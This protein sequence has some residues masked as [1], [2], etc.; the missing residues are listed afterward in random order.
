MK[1]ILTLALGLALS[2]ALASAQQSAVNVKVDWGRVVTTSR[3]TASYQVVVN[4]MLERG[5]KMHDGTFKA[6]STAGADYV[7]YVPW[8]PY[9]RLGVAELEPPTAD[10]TS[11][12]FTLLDPMVEDLMKAQNGHSVIMNFST[13]PAWLWKTDKPVT[14]PKDPNQVYWDYTQGTEIKDPTYKE[15]AAYYARLLS[16]YEKG[17]FTDE[18]GKFHASKYH[19]KFAYWELL[20]EID[21]EHHWTPQEYTK[22]YDVVSAEMRKVDPDLKFM[23]CASA[24]PA[25][26]GEMYRYFLDPKNHA[27]GASIDF[28]TYH[29][30]ASPPADEPFDA[31]QF[32]FFDQADGFLHTARYI[33]QLKHELSPATKTD[34]DELGVILPNDDKSNH[35][36]KTP[37]EP[38]LYWNLAS[39]MYAYLYE[40]AAKFGVDVIG[41]SQLVGYPTQYPSVSMMNYNTSEPNARF[42]TMKL[43][44]DNLGPGDRL[45]STSGGNHAVAIQAFD[46]TKGRKILV[47]NKR[48]IAATVNLPAGSSVQSVAYIAPS[49]GDKPPATANT[50]GSSLSLEPFEV[51]V[52]TV[53]N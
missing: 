32:T 49:T 23:A 41:E 13:M 24:A 29:F 53:G 25:T 36:E 34:L 11:W 14:Y 22:F 33:E 40:E 46:T 43:L 8:L 48:Q 3:S 10:K 38:P 26:H 37:P 4:P 27:P 16:W 17:G 44:K 28:V 52:V 18:N 39:A 9:P 20:N 30:Y 5:A 47:I 45:V 31:M 21:F 15:A 12:D 7:R 2:P 6:I 35:G 42:W 50:H 1:Q 19:Y 51:A